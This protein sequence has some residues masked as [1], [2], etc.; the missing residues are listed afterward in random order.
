MMEEK[1][2]LEG[3]IEDVIENQM[4]HSAKELNGKWSNGNTKYA[5][6]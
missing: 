5:L 2:D 1:W 4:R 3:M 6:G